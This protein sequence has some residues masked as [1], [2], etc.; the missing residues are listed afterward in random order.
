MRR[1]SMSNRVQAKRANGLV[2]YNAGLP[3]LI[4]LIEIEPDPNNVREQFDEDEL[5]EFGRQH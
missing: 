2:T 1:E 5:A 4:P 3:R